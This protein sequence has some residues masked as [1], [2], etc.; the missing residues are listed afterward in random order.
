MGFEAELLA[1]GSNQVF[2]GSKYG[3]KNSS[4]V[5]SCVR[6]DHW[7]L[8][9]PG[10]CGKNPIITSS[11]PCTSW[12]AVGAC[13]IL[14]KQWDIDFKEIGKVLRGWTWVCPGCWCFCSWKCLWDV[15]LDHWGPAKISHPPQIWVLLVPI[16]GCRGCDPKEAEPEVFTAIPGSGAKAQEWK[17]QERAKGSSGQVKANGIFVPNY[18][19]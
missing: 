19:F 7:D 13:F 18:L 12:W 16:P 8:R 1:L 9:D 14:G 2:G 6:F 4:A 5:G 10:L 3:K 17:Q 11:A 15:P